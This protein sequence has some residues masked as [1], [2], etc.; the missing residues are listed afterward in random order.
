METP[1]NNK[2]TKKAEIILFCKAKEHE[3]KKWTN[4]STKRGKEWYSVRFV[5]GCPTPNTHE[6]VEGIR[7]AF[8]G[9]SAKCVYNIANSDFGKVLYVESFEDIS[10]E[11]LSHLLSNEK[12]KIVEYR[13][14]REAEKISFLSVEEDELI[15]NQEDEDL[16]F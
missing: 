8:V 12:A 7:R 6:V 5:K 14:K 15:E 11:R 13:A 10:D 1:N 3:G 2:A 4:F 9:L 16:Q